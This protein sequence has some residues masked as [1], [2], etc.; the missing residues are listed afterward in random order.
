VRATLTLPQETLETRGLQ[1]CALFFH[2]RYEAHYVFASREVRAFLMAW[3]KLRRKGVPGGYAPYLRDMLSGPH[4]IG[5][6]ALRRA[7]VR[8]GPA[9]WWRVRAMFETEPRAVNRVSLSDRK[10]GLGW[11]RARVHWTVS[12]FDLRCMRESFGLISERLRRA[13]V[14]ALELAIPDT[15]EGWRRAIEGGKHH[16]GTTRMHEDPCL[17]VVDP[18]GRVHGCHNLYVTGSSVFPSGGYANPTLTIV[19]LALRLAE[20]LSGEGAPTLSSPKPVHSAP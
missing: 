18:D 11:P 12:D 9:R 16:M 4:R 14:G 10:D 3:D 2:P 13:G 15:P 5:L 1:N 8:E 19:A 20:H 6:A 7:L 17:G